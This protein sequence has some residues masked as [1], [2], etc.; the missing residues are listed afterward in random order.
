MTADEI[1]A[2]R[3]SWEAILRMK[4][5]DRLMCAAALWASVWGQALLKAAEE[6]SQ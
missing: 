3:R 2:A 1:T 6:Q 5:M 4:D